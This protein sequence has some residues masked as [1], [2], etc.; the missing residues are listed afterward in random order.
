MPKNIDITIAPRTEGLKPRDTKGFR[1]LLKI[2]A[3]WGLALALVFTSV[4]LAAGYRCNP[5]KQNYYCS[6]GISHE[7]PTDRPVTFGTGAKTVD[8]CFSCA[9]RDGESYPFYDEISGDCMAC[10]QVPATTTPYWNGTTCVA[11]P[12][13]TIWDSEGLTCKEN[14]VVCAFTVPHNEGELCLVEN[15]DISTYESFIPKTIEDTN[16]FMKNNVPGSEEWG[17][18]TDTYEPNSWAGAMLYCQSKGLR[19]P[20]MQEALS[21]S[22]AV[23]GPNITDCSE[24]C[25][26]TDQ[27]GCCFLEENLSSIQN[28]EL[29]DFIVKGADTAAIWTNAAGYAPL[30]R[31][32]V[33]DPEYTTSGYLSGYSEMC[34]CYEPYSYTLCIK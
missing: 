20:T 28:Q 4:A 3:L 14:N 6:K 15:V 7:C 34:Y 31:D 8:E 24:P 2:K 17:M 10:W 5:C 30:T 21:I 25:S 26:G 23:F 18:L 22:R 33:Y 19:L 16:E 12:E 13:N 1:G 9:D 27:T 32:F 29:W 11:C